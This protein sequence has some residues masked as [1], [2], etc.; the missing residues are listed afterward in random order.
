MQ[1]V[2][3]STVLTGVVAAGVTVM[4][5]AVAGLGV[6]VVQLPVVAFRL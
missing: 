5:L 1:P 4:E 3:A 6:E 2:K